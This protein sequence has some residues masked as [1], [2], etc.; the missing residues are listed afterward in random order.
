MWLCMRTK[1]VLGMRAQT[2]SNQEFWAEIQRIGRP[3]SL[4]SSKEAKKLGG[5]SDVTEGTAVD[6]R[7]RIVWAEAV[8]LTMTTSSYTARGLFACLARSC[9]LPFR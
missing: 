4:I 1:S 3:M 7:L 9:G 6:V 2:P 8:G 5:K